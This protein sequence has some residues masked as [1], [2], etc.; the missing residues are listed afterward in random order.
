MSSATACMLPLLLML[1][2]G[3]IIGAT[4]LS[5]VTVSFPIFQLPPFEPTL[6][7]ARFAFGIAT[8]VFVLLMVLLAA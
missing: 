2:F 1:L 3:V 8:F 6:S 4:A 7:F 5:F